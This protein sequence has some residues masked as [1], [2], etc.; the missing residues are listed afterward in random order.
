MKNLNN[1]LNIVRK[2]FLDYFESLPDPLKKIQQ[3][4]LKRNK[5]TITKGF[6]G[7]SYAFWISEPFNLQEDI[8]Q[9]AALGC[10]AGSIFFL[11]QDIL[12]DE[13]EKQDSDY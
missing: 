6:V 1:K 3:S 7:E 12:I 2:N 11:I 9:S 13:K 5:N 8:V 10:I 4:Y